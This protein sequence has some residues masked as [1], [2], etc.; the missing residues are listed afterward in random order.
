MWCMGGDHVM[1]GRSC[2]ACHGRSCDVWEE[3]NVM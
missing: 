2:D 1:H 3:C